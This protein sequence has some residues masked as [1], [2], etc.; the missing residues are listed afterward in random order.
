L[1]DYELPRGA[2]LYLR[3]T[4]GPHPVSFGGV[5]SAIEAPELMRSLKL[6]SQQ[7]AIHYDAV[8][9]EGTSSKGICNL[10]HL[11]F[12]NIASPPPRIRFSGQ[13][14]HPFIIDL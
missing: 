1:G 14:T 13:L 10:T 3:I 5:I 6:L 4:Y 9:R 12:E 7:T 8:D 11:K 2:L